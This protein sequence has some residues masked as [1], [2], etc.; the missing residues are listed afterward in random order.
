MTNRQIL[1][2]SRPQGIPE[3]ENFRLVETLLGDPAEGQFL[4][5]THYLSV[6]PYMRGRISD[7]KSYADPVALGALMVG[8]T[9]GTVV[10][11]RHDRYREGDVVVGDWGWQEYALTDGAGVYRFDTSLAPM[12]T[13]VGVMG[14]PGL[15]AYAGLLEIGKPNEGETVFVTGAAGAVGSLVGQIAKLKGCYV[16]GSAGS[17]SKVE[18]LTKELGFDAAF[19]Y[20]DSQ[21]YAAAIAEACPQGIDVFYDNVGGPVSDAAFTH[22]NLHARVVICGQIDQYNAEQP[23][24]GPRLLWNLIVKRARVE[25]FLVFDHGHLYRQ[26]QRDISGWIKEGKIKYRETIVDGLE[27]APAAFIGLFHGENLGKQLVRLAND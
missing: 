6:D 7:R 14:M 22:I 8:G 12:S 20:K 11:S 13:A 3:P 15:T 24:Q 16:A 4:V 25:G 5:R 19:N 2:V 9:V 10:A 17:P 21:D 23:P 1:L 18:H 27:N 26:A